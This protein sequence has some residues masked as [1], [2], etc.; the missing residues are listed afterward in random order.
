MHKYFLSVVIAI[1]FLF[2]SGRNVFA[3]DN[4]AAQVQ[5]GISTVTGIFGAISKA[6]NKATSNS[7]SVD[8]PYVELTKAMYNLPLGAP[9]EEIIKWGNEQKV[10]ISSP[11]PRLNNGI[12]FV[13]NN[14]NYACDQGVIKNIYSSGVSPSQEMRNDGLESIGI[15]YYKDNNKLISYAAVVSIENGAQWKLITD[16]LNKKYGT[17]SN[18][19]PPLTGSA[20]VIQ[21]G[22]VG[23]YNAPTDETYWDIFYLTGISFTRKIMWKRNI[24]GN[25]GGGQGGAILYY[26]QNLSKKIIESI[27]NELENCKNSAAKEDEKIK[28]K[29]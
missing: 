19:E 29:F 27:K 26:E 10:K 9:L 2:T 4:T 20:G 1:S 17:C 18:I 13:S 24:I 5:A 8:Y 6:K 14:K 15:F 25:L 28:D 16:A 3:D 7:S 12:P 21:A 11:E 22:I 23:D